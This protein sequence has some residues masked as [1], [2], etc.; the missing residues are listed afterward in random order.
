MAG[1]RVA[2]SQAHITNV[3]STKATTGANIGLCM[4]ITPQGYSKPVRPAPSVFPIFLD[5]TAGKTCQGPVISPLPPA[6]SK[7]PD[8]GDQQ[9][10][11]ERQHRR[12]VDPHSVNVRIDL[13]PMTPPHLKERTQ[14]QTCARQHDDRDHRP[15]CELLRDRCHHAYSAACSLAPPEVRTARPL[16]A[17]RPAMN[18][19]TPRSPS[20]HPAQLSR[21]LPLP[22]PN[23]S[24][25]GRSAGHGSR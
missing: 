19:R 22:P 4:V 15:S 5:G 10:R 14:Q 25:W 21:H 20:A 3:H 17:M 12:P 9:G 18:E 6:Q 16:V 13:R 2:Y 23:G 24:I 7:G 1:M 11:G 8:Q